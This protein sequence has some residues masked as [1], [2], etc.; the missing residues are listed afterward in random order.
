MGNI[1]CPRPS[2]PEG[3]EMTETVSRYRQ[4]LRLIYWGEAGAIIS[5]MYLFGLLGG[6][7]YF[8]D[9][10]V[11][12][13]AYAKCHYCNVL[14]IGMVAF[15]NLVN[16][17]Q[18]ATAS[19]KTKRI[20]FDTNLTTTITILLLVWGSLKLLSSCIIYRDFKFRT[21]GNRLND[22][23]F[24]AADNNANNAGMMQRERLNNYAAME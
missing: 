13:L 1:F 6:V 12:Y 5:Y 16:L 17:F 15:L 18:F 22:D 3:M 7:R 9:M 8:L 4:V 11:A 2:H 21:D 10:W 24:V 20:L 19:G 23:D 14:L